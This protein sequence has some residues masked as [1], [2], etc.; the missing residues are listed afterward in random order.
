MTYAFLTDLDIH[1]LIKEEFKNGMITTGDS[2]EPN[3]K[4]ILRA[5]SQAIRQIKNIISDRY[6]AALSFQ[7]PAEWDEA[8]EYATGHRCRKDDMFF[9]AEDDSLAVDPTTEQESWKEEDP[10]D[11]YL[12]MITVDVMLYHLHAR[13]NPRALTELR[14]KRYDDALKGLK[15]GTLNL[16][17]LVVG[18]EGPI[19]YGFDQ[20]PRQHY[21]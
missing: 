1:S 2:A 20:L 10:R 16:P 8:T 14:V 5:E 6:D 19:M 17:P 4:I 11:E 15:T 21:F 9:V 12:V 18:E 3:E 7:I 13:H